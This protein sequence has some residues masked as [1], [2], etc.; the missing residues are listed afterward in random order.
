MQKS[1]IDDN[2]G[3]KST[4]IIFQIQ[5]Y[6][7]ED[8][9]GIRTTVFLKQCPLKCIWCQNPESIGKTPSIQWYSAKCI[10]C[11]TCIEVCPELAI[12]ISNEN[13]LRINRAKCTACG[14]CVENCPSTAL[15]KF[16]KKW[17][18][19]NLLL[20]VLKDRVY[21]KKSSG[22]VTIS[23]GEPTMQPEFTSEFL[24][25]C[26]EKGISTALDTCGYTNRKVLGKL[27]PDLDLVL[28]DIKEID[29]N[30]H[31]K[32]TGVSNTRILEN[33]AWLADE[34]NQLGKKL[35]IRT[36]LIPGY[37]ARD[38][39]IEGIAA[40]IKHNLKGNID[41][42]DLLAFNNLPAD[43]YARIHYSPWV[44]KNIQPLSRYEMDHFRDLAIS[45]GIK[46]VRWS[47]ITRDDKSNSLEEEE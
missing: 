30:K 44:L 38:D 40:F 16:G 26:K 31:E 37:T 3:P 9:P 28:Y 4:G 10:G 6:S 15:K 41:R 11:E 21:Y 8:G 14:I 36:P 20:E 47:G 24:H 46:I 5:K 27:L 39:N 23:G 18:I 17:N 43:K 29:P 22:G 13:G 32:W 25:L 45:K 7:T 42:W 2:M 19:D 34:I 12:T 1:K 35:W 33:C